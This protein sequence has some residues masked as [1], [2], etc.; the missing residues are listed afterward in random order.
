M[1]DEELYDFKSVRFIIFSSGIHLVVNHIYVNFNHVKLSLT[2]KMGQLR[3][4]P[5][6]QVTNRREVFV[7]LE[8]AHQR[9]Q[10]N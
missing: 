4:R 8:F 9:L 1:Y 6:G 2:R 3:A 7:S 10:H 5:I